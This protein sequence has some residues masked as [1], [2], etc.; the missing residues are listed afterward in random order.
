IITVDNTTIDNTCTIGSGE[1]LNVTATGVITVPLANTPNNGVQL[2]TGVSA[3]SI[4]NAGTINPVAVAL[5]IEGTLTG[6]IT[7]TGTIASTG[8]WGGIT[9]EGIRLSGAT[10]NGAISNGPAGMISAVNGTAIHI[11]NS[12][13]VGGIT[14]AA[15][16]N[17]NT[18]GGFAAL[19]ISNAQI[20]TIDNAGHIGKTP[21]QNGRGMAL[22]SVTLTGDILNSG[23]IDT[24]GGNA[25]L[26]VSTSTVSGKISNSGT[27]GGPSSNGLSVVNSSTVGMIENTATGIIS[28]GTQ[29][30]GVGN[31]TVTSGI[32]NAGKLYGIHPIVLTTS[33]ISGGGILNDTGAET[34]GQRS[35][36]LSVAQISGDIVNRGLMDGAEGGITAFNGSTITGNVITPAPSPPP[37]RAAPVDWMAPAY[38]SAAT[39][40]SLARSLTVRS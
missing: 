11:V 10:V 15:G 2:A 30:I 23:S 38:S 5:N 40:M 31:S 18:A 13:V 12:S 24:Q 16:G 3:V 35:I 4:T 6:G 25:A 37:C 19:D 39:P 29:M 8:P 22:S 14:N 32:V 7:N 17:I 1:S 28:G 20:G 9:E 33:T 34:H 21:G 26:S 27:I 36:S